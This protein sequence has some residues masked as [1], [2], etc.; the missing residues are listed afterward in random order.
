MQIREHLF[1]LKTILHILHNIKCIGL[2]VQTKQT[3]Y[4]SIYQMDF[5]ILNFTFRNF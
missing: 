1:L 3:R 4:L 5:F 2:S